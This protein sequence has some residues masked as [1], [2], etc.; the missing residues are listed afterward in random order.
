MIEIKKILKKNVAELFEISAFWDHEFLSISKHRLLAHFNNPNLKND[1]IVLIVAY[2]NQELAGYMGIFID[3]ITIDNQET[4]IGWLS[5]WWVHPKTKGSGIG[6]EILNE[7]YSGNNG[8]IGISQFTPSAKR[9][10]DKSG[11]FVNL[12]EIV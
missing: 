8:R 3:K 7:M 11:Y 12:K 6:R 9:V 1:D 2:F 4:K 5:T 10:Y